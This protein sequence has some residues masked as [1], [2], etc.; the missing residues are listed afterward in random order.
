MPAYADDTY[1]LVPSDN[2]QTIDAE[3]SSILTWASNNNIPLNREK[4]QEIIFH[5]P[6]YKLQAPPISVLGSQIPRVSQIKILGVSI[7]DT[8]SAT[9]HA[10]IITSDCKS[11]LYALSVIKRHGIDPMKLDM[12]FNALVISRLTYAAPSWSGF[13]KESDWSALQAVLNKGHKWGL[14]VRHYD[15]RVTI[16][17]A[18][19]VLFNQILTD[20][21][22]C[23]HCLLP[24]T[25]SHSHDLRPRPHNRT[26]PV[27]NSNLTRC[28]FLHRMLSKNA[29]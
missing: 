15:I 9:P 16:E 11:R 17:K 6:R 12:L 28:S 1:L 13:L 7:T 4:S 5:K 29:Y 24:P 18:D 21:N 22:H 8:L 19:S 14:S 3:F 26:I 27:A 2:E 23:L 25:K 20:T 10:D